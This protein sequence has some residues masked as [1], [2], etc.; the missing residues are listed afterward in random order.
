MADGG[1]TVGARRRARRLGGLMPGGAA[2]GLVAACLAAGRRA[3]RV[4]RRQ[5]AIA[6][7]CFLLSLAVE[8]LREQIWSWWVAAAV[9]AVAVLWPAAIGYV[10][11]R[12]RLYVLDRAARRIVAGAVPVV[13]LGV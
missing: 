7:P 3:N 2:P 4:T 5:I 11:V 6:L 1:V 10:I 9:L 12:D 13:L 8:A